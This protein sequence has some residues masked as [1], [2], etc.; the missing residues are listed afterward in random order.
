LKDYLLGQSIGYIA[1]RNF[2]NPGGC[3]Y[4]RNLWTFEA[5]GDNPMWRAQSKFYLDFMDNVLALAET[6][7]M[8]YRGNILRVIKLR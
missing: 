2:N 1:F 4:R 7:T 8:I 5:K 3:L 6:E